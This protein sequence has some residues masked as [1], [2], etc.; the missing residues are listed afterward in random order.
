MA[1]TINGSGQVPVRVVQAVKTNTFSTS[2]TSWVDIPD[3]SL[4]I[5]PSSSSNK[6]LVSFSTAISLVAGYYSGGVRIVRNSTP[7]Y[8]GDANGSRVQVSGWAW[9]EAGNFGIYSL[10]GQFLDSPATTSATTY[11]LQLISGYSGIT[12]VLNKGQFDENGAFTGLFPSQ[13]TAME[14]SG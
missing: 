8:I 10:G 14:I 12:V 3:L 5:T 4:T 6:V 11:K 13:I 9:G 7:I 1:V 2:T